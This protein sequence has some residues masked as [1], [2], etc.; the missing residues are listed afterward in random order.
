MLFHQLYDLYESHHLTGPPL[1]TWLIRCSQAMYFT[2]FH[3]NK[4]VVSV[5]H[6]CH[7]KPLV[8]AS[9]V[10]L[11]PQLILSKM[12]N[13]FTLNRLC[14]FTSLLPL[15]MSSVL[16]VKC[17]SANLCRVKRS[18]KPYQNEQDSVKEA[19]ETSSTK[20]AN[21][22]SKYMQNDDIP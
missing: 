8:E 16:T 17:L 7:I 14:G 15:V 13:P 11:Q 19:G 9:I 2:L 21:C 12:F 1:Y 10:V 6:V 18:F 4:P 3:S 5:R 22:D 20:T